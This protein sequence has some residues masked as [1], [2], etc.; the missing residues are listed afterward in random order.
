MVVQNRGSVQ[1]FS[2][3]IACVSGTLHCEG[4]EKN[5]RDMVNDTNNYHTPLIEVTKISF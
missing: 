2:W 1:F 3:R 4:K 5:P